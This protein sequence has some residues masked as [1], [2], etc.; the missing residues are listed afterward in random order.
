M[1]KSSKT[2]YNGTDAFQTR[3]TSPKGAKTSIFHNFR[4]FFY[5]CGSERGQISR[6]RVGR[7]ENWRGVID[8]PILE[9]LTFGQNPFLNI[10]ATFCMI[11]GPRGPVGNPF[12][13]ISRPCSLENMYPCKWR[14]AIPASLMRVDELQLV[15]F[16]FC[17]LSSR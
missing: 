9:L 5:I 7:F 11:L 13:P 10:L 14:I 12:Q 16:T 2:E 17:S 4:S 15:V 8:T 3:V 6:K 1:T